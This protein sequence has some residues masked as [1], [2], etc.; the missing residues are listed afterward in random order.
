MRRRDR[1]PARRRAAARSCRSRSRRRLAL[2]ALAPVA[3][4]A[5]P[6]LV[7]RGGLL[8]PLADLIALRVHALLH[9]R[10]PLRLLEVARLRA[11][12][13]EPAADRFDLVTDRV[14]LAEVRQAEPLRAPPLER[15]ER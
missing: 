12:L 11:P 8:E 14:H 15:V 7:G 13:G 2:G 6:E 5:E 4:E 9:P 1:C 3:L 10:A